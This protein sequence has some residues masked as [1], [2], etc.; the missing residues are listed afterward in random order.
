MPLL[1][2]FTV[3][4][5]G[6][7]VIGGRRVAVVLP[8]YN[9][10]QTLAQ[11]VA[12]LD[13]EI[14]DDILLVDDAS[15]DS[16]AE[17]GQK[18]G[19]H[20]VRHPR[21]VGY[22]GNQKTC[23]RTALARGA[24]IVVMVH[25]DYQYSPRLMPCL[26][27][28]IASGEY[29]V[30]LASRILGNGA[31]RGGMPRYKYFANRILTA[32]ENVLLGTKV[33]EFHTGYRA[34]SREVLNSVRFMELSDNFVFDNQIL[35]QVLAAGFRI[36][37][38]SCPTRYEADSSSIGLRASM[39]YGAG[40]LATAVGYRLHALSWRRSSYLIPID[41]VAQLPDTQAGEPVP[42]RGRR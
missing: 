3:A 16:T 7:E 23:Y 41:S 2:Q 27:A 9:A 42:L 32:T 26:A 21:N 1:R 29:D 33:S 19:L 14:A 34:Y 38:I 35:A 36:G 11:T 5:S 24:D 28:M 40:V 13:G 6:H 15:T 37:E 12:E 31:M 22:G 30:V 39:R 20:V 17:L 25:P 8:A 4:Y 10:E 18:L